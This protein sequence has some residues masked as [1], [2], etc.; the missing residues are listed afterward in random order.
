ML[1]RASAFAARACGDQERRCD[2]GQG[3]AGRRVR[4]HG[5]RCDGRQARRNSTFFMPESWGGPKGFATTRPVLL[6]DRVRCIGDRV[7]FVVAETEAQARDAAE[8][9]AVDYEPLPALVDIEQAAQDGRAENLGATARTAISLSQSRSATRLRRMPRSLRRSTRPRFVWSTTA[10]PRMRSSRAARSASMTPRKVNTPLH[11]TSQDPHGVRTVAGV[12]RTARAR[13][14]NPRAFARRRRRFRHESQYLSRR[15]SGAVGCQ[16]LRA[17]GQMDRDAQRKLAAA[18]THAREQVIY[19][20]L[21]LDE[22][23]KFLGHQSD[24]LSG[25]RR[26]LVGGHR[27]H[28]CSS[29]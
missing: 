21:A 14:E 15:R 3:R 19:G 18:T 26:L 4:A 16:A 6:A 5:R 27:P 22:N 20:E 1:W 28:R 17:A 2:R 11:T 10:L 8:L 24:R 23:G 29:R 9:V 7:A 25:A 12:S 13:I